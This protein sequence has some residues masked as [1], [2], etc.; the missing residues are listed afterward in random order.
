M[1]QMRKNRSGFSMLEASIATLMAAVASLAISDMITSNTKAKQAMEQSMEIAS[2]MSSMAQTF[3]D[4]EICEKVLGKGY[5]YPGSSVVANIFD[6][7]LANNVQQNITLYRV[8]MG[9]NCGPLNNMNCRDRHFF[10]TVVEKSAF[11]GPFAAAPPTAWLGTN[12]L[13]RELYLHTVPNGDVWDNSLAV[14][15]VKTYNSNYPVAIDP[16]ESGATNVAGRVAKAEFV[17][18][19]ENIGASAPMGNSR[20]NSMGSVFIERRLPLIVKVESTP[21]NPWR[22]A[23]CSVSADL[24]TNSGYTNATPGGSGNC[25]LASTVAGVNNGFAVCP[26]GTYSIL[27]TTSV[28]ATW[29]CFPCGKVGICCSGGGAADSTIN[30]CPVSP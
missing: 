16:L 12:L 10:S 27:N 1:L 6:P 11:V 30:C 14:P 23:A 25:T 3:A 8:L 21:G 4:P 28:N 29:N 26:P 20:N 18:R 9:S 22:V 19:I 15:A 7:T 24:I 17:I 2:F 5:R 13:I